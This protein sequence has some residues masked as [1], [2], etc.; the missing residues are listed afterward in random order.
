MSSSSST[1]DENVQRNRRVY[2]GTSRTTDWR[3]RKRE[4]NKRNESTDSSSSEE[5]SEQLELSSSTDKSRE[6]GHNVSERTGNWKDESQDSKSCLSHESDHS[7]SEDTGWKDE[8]EL[9]A[10]PSNQEAGVPES[11]ITGN[12]EDSLC[13]EESSTDSTSESGS[14]YCPSSSAKSFGTDTDDFSSDLDSFQA[15]YLEEEQGGNGNDVNIVNGVEREE[16]ENEANG[17]QEDLF[18]GHGGPDDPDDP[19]DPGYPGEDRLS[20]EE[21]EGLDEENVDEVATFNTE[22]L[23]QPVRLFQ[24]LTKGQVLCLELASAVRHRKTFENI[25]DQLKNLNILFGPHCFPESKSKL[26][27]SIMLN[28]AGVQFHV[29]CGRKDCGRYLG[30]R[31]RFV[32]I[33]RCRCNYTAPVKK[34]KF[35]VT[36]DLKSQLKYFLSIPGIWDKLQYPQTRQKISPT[37]I[38]DILDGAH[39][40][41]LKE[42]GGPLASRNNLS[43]IFNLDGV[44]ASK[45]GS[46]KVTPIYIRINELPPELRQKFHF[47]AAIFIDNKDPNLKCYLKPFVRQARRLAHQGLDW[48]P[49]GVNEINSKI[50]PIAFCVDSPVR[51]E[52]LGLS[53][54][55]SQYGCTYCN[56]RGVREAG[57]QRYPSVNLQ[58]IP[59]FQDR[60]HA[61]MTAAMFHLNGNPH[62]ENHEGHKSVSPL[63]LLDP[64]LDLREGQAEDDLHQDHEGSAADLTELL[65]T[66]REAR[67]NENL[68]NV[69]L[70][71]IIDNRMLSI[72]S[73]SRISRKPRSIFKRSSFSGSEWRNWLF[74]YSVPCLLGLI[75]PVYLDI[76]AALSHACY[77]L[78]QDSIEPHHIEHA[79]RLLQRVATRFENTFGVGRLKFNLHVTTKHKVRSVRNLG[80]PFA[81]STYNF[82]S[83]HRKVIGKVTSPKGAIMQVITRSMLYLTVNASQYDERLPEDVRMRV[84][85]IMNPY[86]LKKVRQ[87]GHH[88]Y[89]IGRGTERELNDEEAA[90][91]AQE[92]IQAHNI[93][94]YSTVSLRSTRYWSSTAQN[95]QIKSNDSFIYTLQETY[96]TL[97]NIIC[98]QND[99][100]EEK[101]G[102]FVIEHDV[103]QVVPVARHIS[104]LQNDDANLLHFIYLEQVRCPALKM[105]IR[106][107][108]YVS[109]VPNCFD[110]D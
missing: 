54:W 91:M 18:G 25:I 82:E 107:A 46:L 23:N 110:I 16:N 26:W 50:I 88:M 100:G 80:N 94:E 17:N 61:G 74:F 99:N 9:P 10:D 7:E 38:E 30:R 93:V 59:A 101:C 108:V 8:S 87:V 106:D 37:A 68:P 56:H 1:A 60:S 43:Y 86:Q 19:D 55:D 12:S 24:N 51:Y 5:G 33:V 36:L 11:D 89:V 64:F 97:Q 104:I 77:L 20:S 92:G 66:T 72:K 78:S 45:K 105:S 62:L 58:G 32:N 83:L 28:K 76:L 2:H 103:A 90:V 4:W 44:Q 52:M 6:I 27:S 22:V 29:Y 75:K 47:L 42:E 81:Y 31:E 65:L 84:E 15:H 21:S 70:L 63:I 67:I 85:D 34:A 109:C 98:F 14:E 35:F 49:D 48:K 71:R 95:Q 102:A 3:R 39:Y 13:D 41:R 96:C 53:K 69:A 40:L 79:E 73:P 57:S